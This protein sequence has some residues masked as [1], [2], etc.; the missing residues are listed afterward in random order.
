[1]LYN[2]DI[3]ILRRAIEIAEMIGDEV[4]QN[5]VIFREFFLN[6]RYRFLLLYMSYIRKNFSTTT[7]MTDLTVIITN[8]FSH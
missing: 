6:F 8:N 4:I 7:T 3:E 2:D 5:K 1:M